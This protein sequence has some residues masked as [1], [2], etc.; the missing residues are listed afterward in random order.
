MGLHVYET[1]RLK[2][3]MF[4]FLTVLELEHWNKLLVVVSQRSVNVFLYEGV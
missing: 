1:V 2:V 4:V 3:L